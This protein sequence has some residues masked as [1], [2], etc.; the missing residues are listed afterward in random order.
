MLHDRASGQYRVLRA[1]DAGNRAGAALAS[2][3]TRGVH[4]DRAGARKAGA[5]P[6]VKQR[7]VFER[8]HRGGHRVERRAARRENVAPGG[9]RRPQPGVVE[10]GARLIHQPSPQCAGAAMHGEHEAGAGIAGRAGHYASALFRWLFHRLFHR[11]PW[12]PGQHR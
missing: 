1:A 11:A 7:V 9:Q 10:H 5:A 3:H 6:G 12:T 2:V 4:L 8:D